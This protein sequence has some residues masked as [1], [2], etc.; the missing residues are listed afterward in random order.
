MSSQPIRVEQTEDLEAGDGEAAAR[1]GEIERPQPVE[2]PRAPAGGAE[3][4]LDQLRSLLLG[5]DDERLDRLQGWLNDPSFRA[6][7]VSA[8]LPRAV[9]LRPLGDAQLGE[10]LAPT[11]E[12]ALVDFFRRD[13]QAAARLLSPVIG[14]ALRRAARERLSAPLRALRLAAT[15][16]GLRWWLEARRGGLSFAEVADRHTLVYRVEHVVL[17]H[18]ATGMQLV[19]VENPDNPRLQTDDRAAALAR[20]RAMLGVASADD[21]TLAGSPGKLGVAVELGPRLALVAL[22]RGN[23]PE[24]LQ[25]RLTA[26]LDAIHLERRYSLKTFAGDPAPFE[27][28]RPLLEKLLAAE[29]D[30]PRAGWAPLAAGAAA[31]AGAAVA[32]L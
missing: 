14:A 2:R 6:A 27:L 11:V 19:E 4:D 9:R 5:Y 28:C 12:T 17:Y 15:M 32:L 22:V 1:Q 24:L 8:I 18:R 21:E 20:V 13:P 3:I 30:E 31:L 7:E 26:T 16:P 25:D 10:A 29:H 23:A